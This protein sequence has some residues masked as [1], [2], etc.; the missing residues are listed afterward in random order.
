M[1][2]RSAT[3]PGR[4]QPSSR[5]PTY[6][7]ESASSMPTPFTETHGATLTPRSRTT[8][9]RRS[10][11]QT[12]LKLGKLDLTSITWSLLRSVIE[13]FSAGNVIM[14]FLQ[15]IDLSEIWKVHL[16]CATGGARAC[17]SSYL[18]AALK[19]ADLANWFDQLI[20]SL[21]EFSLFRVVV[22]NCA[23]IF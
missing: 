15:S 5:G 18:E 21:T 4:R 17:L 12:R 19:R 8:A 2:Y 9:M 11:P 13:R 23:T 22:I 7:P 3:A 10:S 6:R 14:L 16:S 20:T 1:T